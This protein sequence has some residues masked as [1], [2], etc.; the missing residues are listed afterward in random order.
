M[1]QFDW[2]EKS[3][4]KT[5][6]SPK[7]EPKVDPQ[8][9]KYLCCLIQEM[10]EMLAVIGV[11]VDMYHKQEVEERTDALWRW[12]VIIIG[13]LGLAFCIGYMT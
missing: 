12:C 13:L 2:S 7:K 8:D 4:K 11:K 10:L 9:V 5:T 1:S 3:E 6:Y